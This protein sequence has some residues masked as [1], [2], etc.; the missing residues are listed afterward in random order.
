MRFVPSRNRCTYF[1]RTPRRRSSAS[2]SGS[3]SLASRL[4][5]AAEGLEGFFFTG[6]SL[7]TGGFTGTNDTNSIAT[8]GVHHGQNSTATG[9][10]KGDEPFLPERVVGIDHCRRKRIVEDGYGLLEANTV[11]GVIAHVLRRIPRELERHGVN[12]YDAATHGM[13]R[14]DLSFSCQRTLQY[15]ICR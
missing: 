15:Q 1:P 13:R 3:I 5:D 10:S 6:V 7:G 11:L 9:P 8:L 4:L 12:L 14:I 2:Y